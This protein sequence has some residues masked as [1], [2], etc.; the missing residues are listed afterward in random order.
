M[1]Y[2]I[3]RHNKLLSLVLCAMKWTKNSE[4]LVDMP[5]RSIWGA[6]EGVSCAWWSRWRS[7]GCRPLERCASK[8]DWS[9]LSALA[10]F[11]GLRMFVSEWYCSLLQSAMYAGVSTLNEGHFL[12][13][14][15]PPCTCPAFLSVCIWFLV[16]LS[17]VYSLI[18]FPID[19]LP[20]LY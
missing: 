8:G 17:P 10:E 18:R 5:A 20:S 4:L 7:D 13:C 11:A 14:E 16:I 6:A 12:Y 19:Y 2:V 9:R 3:L 1:G 15:G